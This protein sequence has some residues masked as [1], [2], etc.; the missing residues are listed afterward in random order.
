MKIVATADVH[1][2]MKFSSYPSRQGDLAEERFS[3]LARVVELGNREHADLLIVA[4]DLFHRLGVA[5]RTVERAA[6]I[7]A[8][9]AGSAVAVLPG[10]HD[11]I[12]PEGDRLWYGFSNAAAD[13]TIVL[14]QPG[15]VDLRHYDLP[16]TLLAAPCNSLHSSTHRLEWLE[17]HP[18]F[19]STAASPEN[20]STL[21]VGVAHGSLDG[22]TLDSEGHYFP[23]KRQDLASTPAAVW[24]VGHTH[25]FHWDA[26]CRVVVPGTPEADG[27]D[28]PVAGSAALIT[29]EEHDPATLH[30]E[31][32]ELSTGR[33]TFSR[34]SVDLKESVATGA[35]AL[36]EEVL[37]R[38]PD[39]QSLA[40]IEVT[41]RVDA[42]LWR[43]WH[44]A[45]PLVTRDPR[46]LQVRDDAL[47]RLL[48]QDQVDDRY[49]AGSFAH[50]LLSE[51]VA[52]DDHAAASEAIAVLEELER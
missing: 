25:R 20:R 51:L 32:V 4:G 41:G 29:L 47:E 11:Y 19:R 39:Q 16:V 24:L 31:V 3:A 9:F 35:A 1:L 21:L 28:A 52:N 8:E 30:S 48:T 13:S 46:V 49:P 5:S 45:H 17:T 6:S 33:F 2:G 36:A 44:E 23:M 42:D 43:S 27:F 18:R 10:N 7:L 38:I 37:A 40:R 15:P 34:I 14:R 12:A 26:E 50:R 22:L